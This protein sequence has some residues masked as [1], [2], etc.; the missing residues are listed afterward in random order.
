MPRA[1][2]RTVVTVGLFEQNGDV[3]PS[4]DSPKEKE[5]QQA[6]DEYANQ[7]HKATLDT[8]SD[9]CNLEPVV[10]A[11]SCNLALSTRKQM[12]KYKFLGRK[13]GDNW[14]VFR[15]PERPGLGP[16]DGTPV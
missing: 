5:R 7:P 8:R 13:K 10:Q 16:T 4:A 6:H 9:C 14:T 15:T 3:C 12:A 11:R 1:S 2:E